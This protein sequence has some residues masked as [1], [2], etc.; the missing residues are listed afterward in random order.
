ME[1]RYR[2]IAG[3]L[4]RSIR[5]G[6]L[7]PGERLPSLRS[8]C[9]DEGTSLMTALAA[10]RHLEDQGLVQ[11]LPRSGYQVLAR[12]RPPLAPPATPRPGRADLSRE[13]ADI[14]AK[15]LAAV[16]DPG[17]VPL[18]FGCPSPEL[19][20]L[21]S[22][23]RLTA[24][25]LNRRRELWASYSSP[26]GNLELRRQV[27]RRLQARGMAV[28]A[29]QVLL[30]TGAMEALALSLRLLA[31]PG[32]RVAVECP[33]FFGILDAARNAGAQVL[34]LPG[35]PRDGV[36]PA[37]LDAA[38]RRRPVRAAVLMPA[39]AN[40]TGSL[41]PEAR[42][43]A[44]MDTLEARGVALVEDDIYGDLAWDGHKPVPLCA[45]PRRDGLPNLLVGSLSKT[46]LPGGR[47]GYVVAPS[48][49][50]ERLADLKS[51]ST[52]ANAT[53]PELLA[54]ECLASGLFE[55]HLRRFT[56]RLQAGVGVLRDS[57]A[58]H[59]PPGTRMSDPRGGY[60][61]W[62]EL[63]RERDGLA[64]F[65]AALERRISIAPGCLFTLGGGLDR[66]I[67]LNGGAAGD[68]DRAAAVLG[69]LVKGSCQNRSKP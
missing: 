45:L 51:A 7:R 12:E 38:C 6:L 68:L 64:L 10:Y 24:S 66:F 49:W 15:T 31:D 17:L 61:L 2:T 23:R 63:P 19:F 28:D 5:E 30:T 22:L 52:L 47:V 67:R 43:R 8:L 26:P 32:D 27:A 65:H 1:P 9:R 14:I 53:L 57:V 41:M 44:W 16:A 3:Q 36:D 34:E 56:G 29:D 39:F 69:G 59:F 11:A 40:P 50:I 4:A 54:A 25:L 35:D 60:L 42:K 62:V 33:T 18:G 20:P 46:L 13:R 55:R 21:G 58:R 48:P 37:R